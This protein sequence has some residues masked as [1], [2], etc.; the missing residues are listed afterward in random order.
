MFFCLQ[1]SSSFPPDEK[2]IILDPNFVADSTVVIVSTVL[3][4]TLVATT[5]VLESTVLGK[6]YPFT[7]VIYQ[8]G[9]FM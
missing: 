5:N 4:E 2:Q 3:P 1:I 8:Q 7:I 6:R 9:E